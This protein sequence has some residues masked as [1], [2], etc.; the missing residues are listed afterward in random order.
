MRNTM[1][2]PRLFVQTESSVMASQSGPPLIPFASMLYSASGIRCD[3]GACT[4]GTPGLGFCGGRAVEPVGCCPKAMQPTA[5]SPAIRYRK[6]GHDVMDDLPGS[7]R[8]PEVTPAV[9]VGEF[10]VIDA[11][12]IEDGRMEIVHMCRFLHR[13]IAE[14]VGGA[15]R[16]AALDAAAGHP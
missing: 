1:S 3:I 9:G 12:Q 7:V 6:L 14:V 16:D 4:P 8:Q 10:Q 13:L 2:V 11:E 15:M 5:S